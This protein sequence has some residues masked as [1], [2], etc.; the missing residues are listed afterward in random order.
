MRRMGIWVPHLTYD[1][2][3]TGFR[4]RNGAAYVYHQGFPFCYHIPS[5]IH[6][7]QLVP[8]GGGLLCWYIRRSGDNCPR[9][10]AGSALFAFRSFRFF[11]SRDM[12]TRRETHR[13]SLNR[14]YFGGFFSFLSSPQHPL[15]AYVL[16]SDLLSLLCRYLGTY[17]HSPLQNEREKEGEGVKQDEERKAPNEMTTPRPGLQ[18]QTQIQIHIIDALQP[19]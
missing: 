5:V 6:L 1:D 16:P 10:P 8:G 4:V 3:D 15:L 14:R 19:T 7:S 17:M 9:H 2:Q 11:L 13:K 18:I 12:R